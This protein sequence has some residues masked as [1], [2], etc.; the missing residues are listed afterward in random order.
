MNCFLFTNGDDR[1][2]E[3]GIVSRA[4]KVSSLG[5]YEFFSHHRANDPRCRSAA[6]VFR[7]EKRGRRTAVLWSLE[8]EALGY[9]SDAIVNVWQGFGNPSLVVHEDEMGDSHLGFTFS[10]ND[11]FQEGQK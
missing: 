2:D 1:D 3:D 8:M 11:N 5:S 6:A 9:L 4:S 10:W 7:L